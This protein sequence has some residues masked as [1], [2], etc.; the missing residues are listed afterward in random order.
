MPAGSQFG[1]QLQYASFVHIPEADGGAVL[2]QAA[3]TRG[4]YAL[5]G[6]GHRHHAA[7]KSELDAAYRCGGGTHGRQRLSRSSQMPRPCALSS[8][9]SAS[10]A[11]TSA[12]LSGQPWAC[13]LRW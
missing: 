3:R 2:R 1:C 8:T 6:A 7:L 13:R 12:S 9:S 4:A 5:R 11:L 10:D